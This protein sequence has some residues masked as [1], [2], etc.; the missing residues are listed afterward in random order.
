MNPP[1]RE[2][3]V[4][5]PVAATP[6]SGEELIRRAGGIR[7][8]AERAQERE[9]EGEHLAAAGELELG[10]S[11]R[12]SRRSCALPPVAPATDRADAACGKG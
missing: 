12:R 6:R 1:P 10:A 3:D 11:A 5:Q 8:L 4:A 7:Y 2:S 9:L